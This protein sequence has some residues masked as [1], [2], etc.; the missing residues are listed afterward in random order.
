MS[1]VHNIVIDVCNAIIE[2]MKEECMPVP[3]R[4]KWLQISTNFWNLWNFPNCLGAIDGK[5]VVIT[6]PASSGS[7]YFNYKKTFSIVLMAVVDANFIMCGLLA[8]Y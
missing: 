4:E 2:Q 1:T 8:F 6:A 7:L 5:H 3:T